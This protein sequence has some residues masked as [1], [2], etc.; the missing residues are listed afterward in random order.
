MLFS[1]LVEIC[2]GK[3][4]QKYEDNPITTLTIDSRQV[5]GVSEEVFFCLIGPHHNGHNYIQT[6]YQKGVRNFVISENIETPGESNVLLVENTLD[7]FQHIG[8]HT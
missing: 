4:V 2:K 3:W 7:A 8:K 1:T 5:S 6:A